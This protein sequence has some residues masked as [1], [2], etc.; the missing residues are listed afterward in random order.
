[1]STI[2]RDDRIDVLEEE[3][4]YL[5]TALGQDIIQIQSDITQL[6]TDVGALQ[7]DVGALQTDVGA[8]NLEQG[9]QNN[10][11]DAIEQD[12]SGL[13]LNGSL[14]DVSVGL[15]PANNDI[16]KW[17]SLSTTWIPAQESPFPEV[18]DN[19]NYVRN[20]GQWNTLASTTEITTLVTDLGQLNTDLG[21]VQTD[22]SNLQI[23]VQALQN[24]FPLSLN[25]L[26]DVDLTIAPTNGQIL[27][28]NGT[29]FVAA[30]QTGGIPEAAQDNKIYG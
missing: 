7:T 11:L 4:D 28:F 23:D 5:N 22:V 21:L 30:N 13:T 14:V 24:Q 8:I 9:A 29:N 26:A 1:M 25:S 27:E 10:R 16:L 2:Y 15:G 3:V 17:N 18:A 6:Q 20:V 12:L 19:Q